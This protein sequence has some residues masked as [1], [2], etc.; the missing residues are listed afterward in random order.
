MKEFLI[1]IPAR[2]ASTRLPNKPLVDIE[3]K[4]MIQRT[5]EQCLLAVDDPST[6]V[7]ATDHPLIFDHIEALG[8][9]A[10]MTSEACLTGTD[11]VAEVAEQ[12]DAKYYINVQGDEPLI[13][14]EDIKGII[15]LIQQGSDEILNGYAPID[16]RE[17]YL[18]LTIPKVVFRNDQRLLY[19]SRAAIPGNKRGEFDFGYRQICI[20]GFPKEALKAFMGQKTKT[21]FEE[22]E[23][24]EI[25]RFLEMGL[26][27][28]MVLMSADSI[29]VDTP[30]DLE[31][32]KHKIINTKL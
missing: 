19:M 21:S 30:E 2:L 8:Y 10:L 11:R 6:I 9:N 1:V 26:E 7:V 23:D 17:D 31:K 12:I 15:S 16:N 20:Y 28:R 4:S 5:Y 22:Q 13:N 24:I 32:V 14:P 18:S 25:L 29:A 3:G 27:V